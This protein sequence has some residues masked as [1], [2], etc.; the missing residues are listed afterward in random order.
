MKAYLLV[1][2]QSQAARHNV[3]DV[4]DHID[5]ANWYAFFDHAFCVASERDAR[6]LSSLIHAEMPKQRFILT[7]VEPGKKAGGLPKS[8]WTFFKA[9]EPATAAE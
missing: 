5:I 7:E 4:I 3:I 2:D 8:I 9:P 6:S 1:F